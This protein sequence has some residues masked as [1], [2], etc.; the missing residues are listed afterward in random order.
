MQA[1]KNLLVNGIV[2]AVGFRPF[3][4][5]LALKLGLS[6]FVCNTAKGVVIEV[7]GPVNILDNFLTLL[8]KEAPALSKIE[9]IKIKDMPLAKEKSFSIKASSGKNAQTS[10]PADI[11]ICKDCQADITDKNNLRYHY[12]FTNCTSCGPR[13]TIIKTLPY[14]RAKTTMRKFKMCPICQREFQNPTDRRFHAQPNCCP[15]CGPRVRFIYKGKPSGGLHEAAKKLEQGKIIAIKSLGGFHL[16][17]NA[18]DRKTVALL[19][20]RKKRPFKPLALMF[21]DI[22]SAKKYCHINKEE[23]NLLSSPQAPIVM[24]TK[25]QDIPLIA[26]GLPTIG[27][28]LPYTPLHKI[29]FDIFQGPLV[30]TSGNISGEPICITNEEVQEKLSNI[31]DGFLLH[32]RDIYN[33]IDD[34]VLFELGGKTY[35]LRR[36]RGYVPGSI[37]L[38]TKVKKQMLAYGGDL[39]SAF[40]LAKENK[41][42]LSQYI[43]D[44]D[45]IKNTEYFHQTLI[46]TQ[47]L[48]NIKPQ[49]FIRDAH[50]AYH[51]AALKPKAIKV[52]HH[53]AHALSVAAEHN[54]DNF[55][56]FSFDGTG[57]GED[58][59]I[60]GAEFLEINKN[61]WKRIGCMEPVNIFGGE[62]AST[63]IWKCGLSYMLNAG[64]N[65]LEIKNILPK[66]P[67]A[68]INMARQNI[69]CYT[70]SSAGRLFDA[71]AAILG[72]CTKTTY[73]AEGAMR[74]EG[75]ATDKTVKIYPFNIVQDKNLLNVKTDAIIK[76]LIAAR[77]KP[78]QAASIFHNTLAAIIVAVASKKGI[79]NIALTGGVFQNKKLLRLCLKQLK[80][81]GFNVFTNNILPTGD[82]G[83]AVG[84]IY[85]QYKNF[86]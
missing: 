10:I 34:S 70:A 72:I 55:L 3:V 31:A 65:D 40:C 11:A 64:L 86:V 23:E 25:K 68:A 1:R 57:L 76:G 15:V 44:L 79:K 19:R 5:N 74:L 21:K 59:T 36:A 35:F 12:P 56:A 69:N 24:L 4:Y 14:D 29:I 67:A 50:P 82:G 17:C 48:L 83:I 6:G 58:N 22:T 60:W 81:K 78:Q 84:Q 27:V 85:A 77:A 73:Q 39:T 8:R 38:P 13:F 28:M 16:A 41:L 2:Q 61:K 18:L 32:N 43:G 37:N 62:S 49:V 63:D 46:K 66:I 52:Q 30:M 47:K 42:Y 71:A 33:R 75:A 26:E 20:K 7:Q 45:K 80:I 54:I 9:S 51:G 53:L